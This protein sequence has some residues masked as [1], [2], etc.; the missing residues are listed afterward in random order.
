MCFVVSTP[1]EKAILVHVISFDV[2]QRPLRG[3]CGVRSARLFPGCIERGPPLAP[4]SS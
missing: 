1:E 2:L 3:I 4:T